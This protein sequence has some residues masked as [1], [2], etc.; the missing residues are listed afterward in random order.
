MDPNNERAIR[1]FTVSFDASSDRWLVSEPEDEQPQSFAAKDEALEAA[2][3]LAQGHGPSRLRVLNKDGSTD[4]E[5]EYGADPLVT[6]L[7]KFGF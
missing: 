3:K 5:V 1:Q 6:Q 7:G 2:K 4:T